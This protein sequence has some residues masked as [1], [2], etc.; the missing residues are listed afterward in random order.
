M[1]TAAEK[2]SVRN[3]QVI[4][5]FGQKIGGAHKDRAREAAERLAGVDASALML[6]P[7]SKVAK[8]PDLRGLYLAGVISERAARR[9]RYYWDC[10]GTKPGSSWPTRLQR[11]ADR[12]AALIQ[13]VADVLTYGDTEK[14]S[15]FNNPEGWKP[16]QSWELFREEMTAANWPADEYKRGAYF[17]GHYWMNPARFSI[18]TEKG[19][20]STAFDSVAE[21][22][23]AIRAKVEKNT[24]KEP[25]K[26]SMYQT[27]AGKYFI[28]PKGKSGIKLLEFDNSA[29]A[30]AAYGDSE[31]LGKIYEE[32]K[33]FPS[34]RRDWNRPRLGEDWRGGQ[35]MTPEAFGEVF[36]FRGVEFGNWVNQLERAACLNE[37]ADALNDLAGVI[38][39]R[40]E[41]VALGGSLAWAFGSRGVGKALAH[42]EPARR[43]VNLTK[44]KG[45][46][47]V[48][49]EWF[50][51]LDNYMMIKAGKPS[52]MAVSDTHAY[53]DAE[54]SP[55]FEAAKA[56]KNALLKSDMYTRSRR[57]DAFRSAPYW[58]TVTE[59]AARGF[60]AVVFY[61]LQDAGLCNDY[62]VSIKEATDYTRSECYPY[63]TREEAAELAPLYRSFIE[64]AFTE[65]EREV[66]KPAAEL[67]AP[68]ALVTYDPAQP[69]ESAP[70]QVQDEA[71]AVAASEPMDANNDPTP[72]DGVQGAAY[73]DAEKS[74][75][76]ETWANNIPTLDESI[77]RKVE[78]GALT[79]KEA[80]REF[81]RHG[82][83]NYT[84]EARAR[85][86]MYRQANPELLAY[87]SKTKEAHPDAVILYRCG[88]F[89]E[90]HF[91]DVKP[92]TECIGITNRRENGAPV[93]GFPHHA[94]D[95]YLPKLIRAGFRI[96]ICDNPRPKVQESA[97]TMG[98]SEPM[99]K[100]STD[101]TPADGDAGA[102]YGDCE[103]SQNFERDPKTMHL[104]SRLEKCHL[105]GLAFRSNSGEIREYGRNDW[106]F[107]ITGLGW[108][109]MPDD[110]GL[111]YTPIGGRKALGKI[112]SAGGFLNYEGFQFVWPMDPTKRIS[113]IVQRPEGISRE[114][115]DAFN[116]EAQHAPIGFRQYIYD[117]IEKSL[118]PAPVGIE[119]NI[120]TPIHWGI[121]L[122]VSEKKFFIYFDRWNGTIHFA[123]TVY[124]MLE[125][126]APMSWCHA[127]DGVLSQQR[128]AFSWPIPDKFHALIGF[129]LDCKPIY[130]G[131]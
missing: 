2:N 106:A 90:C 79:I 32:L 30:W 65:A 130:A 31:K 36:P 113:P 111:P 19:S 126:C 92:V 41:A 11:W 47:C 84:D 45:N 40:P 67:P 13:N 6:Q 63:P 37:C 128:I 73:G 101:P 18:H 118:N 12:A 58:A 60:E 82:W 57:I 108:V 76:S 59:M 96:V 125:T 117:F 39:I 4:N 62:L 49:H 51:A 55:I 9:A 14:S 26:F 77:R 25:Q 80:A 123:H 28:S 42:Y 50:H 56:L 69:I 107:F 5:D 116:K 8:L 83:T 88:D 78:T 100:N 35:D 68:P 33:K 75:I 95:T 105:D 29:D 15:V 27:S 52:L 85:V 129:D 131:L 122:N 93:A 7:L 53:G 114:D 43:V 38:G 94:L 119:W 72:A 66:I 71:P 20:Y 48:A 112:K 86:F 46:G 98:A 104:N 24:T 102:A 34:E 10:I 109:S 54:K 115:W 127:L 121:V 17:V 21:C 91:E 120:M 61:A 103:K 23:K 16:A 99:I 44:K 110:D 3:N 74:Q 1:T 87:H 64:A 70:F 124:S 81:C 89:Y 97:P 22:V